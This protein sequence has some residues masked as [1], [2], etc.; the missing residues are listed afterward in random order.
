MFYVLV[1]IAVIAA[2]VAG[3]IEGPTLQTWLKNLSASRAVKAAQA[4]IAKAEADAKALEAAHAVVAKAQ[5]TATVSA[6]AVPAA[7]A[8][9]AGVTGP[10]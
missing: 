10:A 2:F 6:A 8:V 9:V 4:V 3:A 7:A 5:T 1:A